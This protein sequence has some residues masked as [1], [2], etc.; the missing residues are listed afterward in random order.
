M[1]DGPRS[2]L[3]CSSPSGR[4]RRECNRARGQPGSE[5]RR[6]SWPEESMLNDVRL[7]FRGLRNQPGLA[8]LALLIV[9]L[10]A[11]ANGA[12][13]SI[14][15]AVLLRP[16]PYAEPERLVAIAPGSFYSIADIDLLT[17]RAR[18]F[19]H[20]ASSSPGWMLS[21]VGVAD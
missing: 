1:A 7:A 9:A 16:L 12:V 18:S 3:A 13:F 2:D 15:R 20:L 17:Q 11:G 6:P 10:G 14:V 8:A 21:L 19:T 5:F 4:R